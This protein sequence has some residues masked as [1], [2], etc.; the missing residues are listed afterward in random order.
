MK[1]SYL[2]PSVF[3]IQAL[4]LF[5]IS[6][7]QGDGHHDGIVF[8]PSVAFSEGLVV[9]KDAFSLYGPLN[10]WLY[11]SILKFL[12]NQVLTLRLVA[13]FL[14][15]ATAWILYQ[16]LK[17][18]AIASQAIWI[19]FTWTTSN[20]VYMTSFPGSPLP[21]A[22]ITANLSALIGLLIL[23]GKFKE[24]KKNKMWFVSG[25]FY[26]ISIFARLQF[27]VLIPIFLFFILFSKNVKFRKSLVI[28]STGFAMGIISILV[29]L[30]IQGALVSYVNQAVIYPL[31]KFPSLGLSTNYNLYLFTLVLS[32]PIISILFLF[33]LRKLLGKFNSLLSIL[34][35]AGFLLALNFLGRWTISNLSFP[36]T[37]RVIA[38][39]I[40][41]KSGMWLSY[42]SAL[43]CLVAIVIYFKNYLSLDKSVDLKGFAI[44]ST[45]FIGILQL[46]PYPDVLHLWWAAPLLIPSLHFIADRA[47]TSEFLSLCK[48]T[49]LIG[50]FFFAYFLQQ[51]W[52][53][54]KNYSL[55]GVYASQEKVELYE[56][57]LPIENYQDSKSYRFDCADG[58][59][60]VAKGN[61]LSTDEWFINVSNIQEENPLSSNVKA[62]FICDKKLSYARDYA[63]KLGW[64]ISFFN[65]ISNS[66]GTRSLAILERKSRRSS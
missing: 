45:G 58:V 49:I 15:L 29:I 37:P 47:L 27:I 54:F 53:E 3:A 41:E 33:A 63:S 16:V 17:R 42:S 62:V 52:Y 50:L 57:Y 2:T 7:F 61:Y 36:L 35:L 28:L 51:P 19:S 38:G 10:V 43:T 24:T 66:T 26:G 11:G 40:F 65:E 44:L 60:S 56:V 20:A 23:M 6:P 21:W 5:G 22:S 32:I 1:Q 30:F 31:T 25:I 34:L 48:A 18:T 13:A 59:H 46:Y 4:V 64:D 55:K 9:Q 8:A 14:S 39:E 12:P